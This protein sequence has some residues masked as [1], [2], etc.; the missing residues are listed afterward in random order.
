VPTPFINIRHMPTRID[1]CPRSNTV[2]DVQRARIDN[3]EEGWPVTLENV[4]AYLKMDGITD[5]DLIISQMITEG[6]DWIENYCSISFVPQTVTAYLLIKNRIE[7]PFGPVVSI[8]AINDVTD[9]NVDCLYPA[10]GFV[11]LTGYGRYKVDYTAGYT[12]YPPGLIG[13]LYGYVAYAYEHRGD[14]F[15]EN[16]T[17]FAAIAAKKAF[18]FTRDICF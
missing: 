2:I 4:K 8:E 12:E 9:F 18:P 13:A 16:S 14:Q 6:I 3:T 15:D 10:T 1:I 5:D 17:E 11:N 7:L